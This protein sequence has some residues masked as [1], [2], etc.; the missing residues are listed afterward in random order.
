MQ[1]DVLHHYRRKILVVLEVVK[2]KNDYND[3]NFKINKDDEHT[4]YLSR[5]HI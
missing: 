2:E 5:I 1:D 3:R 4:D